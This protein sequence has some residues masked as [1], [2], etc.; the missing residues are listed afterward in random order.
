MYNLVVVCVP[1]P[2]VEQINLEGEEGQL[3]SLGDEGERL[4]CVLLL[5]ERGFFPAAGCESLLDMLCL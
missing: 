1:L 2:V 5:K 3:Q 4:R